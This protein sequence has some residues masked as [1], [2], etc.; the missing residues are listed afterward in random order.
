MKIIGIGGD[1]EEVSQ[2][3]QFAL[4]NFLYLTMKKL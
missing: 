4:E 1:H 2:D 3:W